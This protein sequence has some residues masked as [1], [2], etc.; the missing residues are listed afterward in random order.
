MFNVKRISNF[1]SLN[2]VFI[3][4]TLRYDYAD[5]EAKMPWREQA[6]KSFFY[7]WKTKN[8][9][10]IHYLSIIFFCSRKKI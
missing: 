8:I 10:V 5:S 4:N 6:C 2:F 9:L 3:W 7:L 1:M